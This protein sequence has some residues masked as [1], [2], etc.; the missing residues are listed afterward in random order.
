MVERCNLRDPTRR[1]LIV[2]DDVVNQ[3]V[4][5]KFISRASRFYEC[6]V[7]SSVS[8]ASENIREKEPDLIITDLL[9]PEISGFQLL[10][11]VKSNNFSTFIPVIVTT[12][13]SDQ[14]LCLE[15]LKMGAEEFINWPINEIS[16]GVKVRNLL[17]LKELTDNLKNYS[18]QLEEEVQQQTLSLEEIYQRTDVLFEGLSIFLYSGRYKPRSERACLRRRNPEG[19]FEID[20]IS[21][22][23]PK[24]LGGSIEEGC[25]PN[26]WC[27]HFC[28]SMK[29]PACDEI[30]R[31]LK[32][33]GELNQSLSY[34][35]PDGSKRWFSNGGRVKFSRGFGEDIFIG[36]C[37]DITSIKALEQQ[38]YQSQ[39]MESLGKLAG[40]VAHDF[41]N[42]LTVIMNYCGLVLEDLSGEDQNS[43]DIEEILNAAQMGS[44]LTR[45]LL[46]FCRNDPTR[47][48][49]LD[50]NKIVSQNFKLLKRTVGENIDF[51]LE[52]YDGSVLVEGDET[53]V[54]Q[55]ILN[56][57]VNARDAMEGGGIIE[58][59]TSLEYLPGG[60]A[61]AIL[62]VC[63]SGQGM[64]QETIEKI[65]EPF[66]TTKG[67]HKGTGLGL[68]CC[69]G[70][71]KN[72]GGTI[73]V[74][75]EPGVGS[76]F[77]LEFPI[78]SASQSYL[79]TSKIQPEARARVNKESALPL[80][81]ARIPI[82]VSKSRKI[83]VIDDEIIV[84]KLLKKL[85][86][87]KGYQVHVVSSGGEARDL[88]GSDIQ[89]T[90]IVCDL[91]LKDSTGL[92]LLEWLRE[93]ANPLA[94]RF[95]LT[96]GNVLQAKVS[97]GG[98]SQI[99]MLPKPFKSQSLYA[100]IEGLNSYKTSMSRC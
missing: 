66:F 62:K 55:L 96:S 94:G 21:S 69:Y 82:S 80:V 29:N 5:V 39:K 33:G 35:H 87:S 6:T 63:D 43:R 70:I 18:S 81:K 59:K 24:L 54:Q 26:L 89:F 22:N 74:D 75:S 58:L 53:Q 100:A 2:D 71:M 11:Q 52:L 79:S 50:L 47:K 40:G 85:L 83:L 23:A 84:G 28:S 72:L 56:L 34:K 37:E 92:E 61:F 65:F 60:S 36:Y 30:H 7:V 76:T 51:H 4:L 64:D 77:T 98:K 42:L 16:L 27:S 8:Q 46:T 90:A 38:F 32:D 1:I 97:S 99:P 73:S 48:E 20:W 25:S 17:R 57:C 88:I 67:I 10:R 93:K 12:A 95:I 44:G 15:A 41:N 31:V 91:N 68:S 13:S 19:F 49:F 9:M 3:K 45:Q 78:G 14:E 86:E